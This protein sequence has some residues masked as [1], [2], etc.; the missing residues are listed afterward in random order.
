MMKLSDGI[1]S[2]PSRVPCTGIVRDWAE[3]ASCSA[4]VERIVHRR[5]DE[6][7]RTPMRRLHKGKH[8]ANAATVDFRGE[9]EESLVRL[10]TMDVHERTGMTQ[11]GE[12]VLRSTEP[13]ACPL[14]CCRQ[15]QNRT[16]AGQPRLLPYMWILPLPC[17]VSC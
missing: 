12:Q 14:E 8:H 9:I 11:V 7:I 2:A 15:R 17:M 4:K 1:V 3:A 16:S 10:R 13:Q 6:T 5:P